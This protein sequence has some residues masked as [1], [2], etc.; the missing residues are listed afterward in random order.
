MDR[1]NNHHFD[2][3]HNSDTTVARHFNNCHPNLSTAWKSLSISVVSFI[4][5]H[6]DTV[7]SKTER[8]TLEKQWMHKLGTIVPKGLNLME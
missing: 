5:S 7:K 6:P 1:F 2:L 4:K 3:A 8:D